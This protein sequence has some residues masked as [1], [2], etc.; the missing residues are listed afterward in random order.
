VR[1]PARTYGRLGPR[2]DHIDNRIC[3]KTSAAIRMYSGIEGIES[4]SFQ[5]HP[6]AYLP[7][8]PVFARLHAETSLSLDIYRRCYS[9][10][11]VV[12]VPKVPDSW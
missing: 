6:S 7:M 4:C 8:F 5:C 2:S 3:C 1:V 10:A 12:G 9:L 11:V